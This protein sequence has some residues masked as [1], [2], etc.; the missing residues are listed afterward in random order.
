MQ[1][2]N[3]IGQGKVTGTPQAELITDKIK[4]APKIFQR[5]M[6]NR[7]EHKSNPRCPQPHKRTLSLTQQLGQTS[8]IQTVKE[9]EVGL[10]A[11]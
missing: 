5:H 8:L 3:N 7:L 1:T 9:R 4:E 2:I 6:S 11:L 10:K